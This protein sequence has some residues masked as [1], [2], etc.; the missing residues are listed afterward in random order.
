V[1]GASFGG[2]SV[3]AQLIQRP[4]DYRCGVDMVGVANWPRVIE[5]WPP[6]WR[7]RHYFAAFFGD[8]NK[9]EER[10]AMLANS[11]VSQIDRIT[12]PLLVI[13]GSNDIRVLREDSDDVVAELRKLG[14]PVD[15][16]SFPDEGHQ[17]RKWRNR[18]AMWRKV[19]DTLAS[20]L[21][22]RSNGFDFYELM[23]R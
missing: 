8:V 15:F 13:H 10:A 22:G 1:L 9:P 20:C 21:G 7:N 6:F 11:P 19:E 23:P 2:F 16:M 12:A 18:L 4:H 5:N 14:R 3:L 17:V